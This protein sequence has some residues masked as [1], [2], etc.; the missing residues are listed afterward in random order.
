MPETAQHLEGDS[1]LVLRDPDGVVYLLPRDVLDAHRATEE[2]IAAYRDAKRGA[3]DVAGYGLFGGP[4]V[5][6]FSAGFRPAPPTPIGHLGPP[7]PSP[8]GSWCVGDGCLPD[9]I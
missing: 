8:I 7:Q 6:G 1:P 9:P 2:Q 5:P 3:N 4:S